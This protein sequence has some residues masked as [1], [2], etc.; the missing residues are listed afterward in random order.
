MAAIPATILDGL[1]P[2]MDKYYSTTLPFNPSRLAGPPPYCTICPPA[3]GEGRAIRCQGR[4]ASSFWLGPRFRRP[5]SGC[6][7]SWA[8]LT[9]RRP[10]ARCCGGSS[11]ETKMV[12]YLSRRE[13]RSSGAGRGRR[14]WF[15]RLGPRA[16]WRGQPRTANRWSLIEKTSESS[17][18]LPRALTRTCS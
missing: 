4:R 16:R 15:A 18:L 1:M 14:A 13:K 12:V 2:R 7:P 3:H 17:V 5:L 11:R 9:R 6:P 8:A 10:P